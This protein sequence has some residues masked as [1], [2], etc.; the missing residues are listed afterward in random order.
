M[1][2]DRNPSSRCAS[3]G[4]GVRFWRADGSGANVSERVL[5]T[6]RAQLIFDLDGV[7]AM[8]V[9]PSFAPLD[10][11]RIQPTRSL[12][13]V[14]DHGALTPF[15]APTVP[16]LVNRSVDL[17][18]IWTLGSLLDELAGM[19][20][21]SAQRRIGHELA[22]RRQPDDGG[23]AL[24]MEAA[25]A[26]RSGVDPASLSG[27][28]SIDRRELVPLFRRTIGVGPKHFANLQRF[29]RSLRAMRAPSPPS[30]AAIAAD[31]GYCDQAHLTRETQ[32]FAGVAPTSL[33]GEVTASPN[34]PP[35]DRIFKTP[36][37]GQPRAGV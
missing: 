15:V 27:K 32:S 6:G 37:L 8:L 33:L 23:C 5:P 20:T 28:M 31:H 14:F 16:D 21:A 3:P 12:G 24:T 10:I 18:D 22:T 34:H 30:L 2:R 9:G 29:R 25:R 7:S 36:G 4:R 26:V 13:V 17:A 35:A 1:G 11:V 19:E